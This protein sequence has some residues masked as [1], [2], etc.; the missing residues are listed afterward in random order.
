MPPL[1][2]QTEVKFL[3]P[4]IT[5]SIKILKPSFLFSGKMHALLFRKWK[6]RIKGRDFYDLLWYVGKKIPLNLVYL[7][8][9]MR[10]GNN[11]K[12]NRKLN[13]DDLLSI[14]ESRIKEI[15]FKMAAQDI[16]PFIKDP[17][18]LSSWN[19]EL[20]L[21]AVKNLITE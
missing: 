21:A 11:W 8:N 10:E 20:F 19:Q 15:D 2:F 13:H 6:K 12:E 7:E 3:P 17:N 4:P 5:T 14:L 9:K 16:A 18:E 1:G